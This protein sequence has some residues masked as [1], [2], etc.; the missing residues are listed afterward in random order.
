MTKKLSVSEASFINLIESGKYKEL[1]QTEIFISQ[2]KEHL[3]S[4]L[5]EWEGKRHAFPNLNMVAKFVPQK[6]W[7]T[8]HASLI[9]DL[10][11]YVKPEYI[12]PLISFNK[13][14]TDEQSYIDIKPF[15]EEPTFFVK[16]TLNKVGKKSL[17]TNDYLFGGQSI[18]ELITEIRDSSIQY[19]SLKEAYEEFKRSA[20]SCSVLNSKKKVPTPFGSV[21]LIK[22]QADWS[23]EKV[24]KN[25][26]EGYLINFGKVNLALLDEY[27]MSGLIPK[28]IVS[29]HRQI[30]DITLKF[31]VMQLDTEEKIMNIHQKKIRRLS[32]QRYA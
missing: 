17:M 1:K 27:M 14:A 4:S 25:L 7:E 21:S 12:F 24:Y 31:V 23:S 6:K 15:I 32:L 18:E 16:S 2:A 11:C 10:F 28:H 5:N 19:R 26:G 30:T 8:N 9:E 29:P 13:K 20:E 3:R 22:K